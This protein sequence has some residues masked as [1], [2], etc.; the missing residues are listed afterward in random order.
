M[1]LR[2]PAGLLTTIGILAGSTA[3]SADQM[4][5]VTVTAHRPH[6]VAAQTATD[7]LSAAEKA[8]NR[9]FKRDAL[10]SRV[11]NLWI[12]PTNDQNSVFV[13]YELR[14]PNGTGSRRQLAVLEQ[15]GAEVTRIVDL[16][17]VPATRVA[18]AASGG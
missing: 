16:V 15:K 5:T 11:S 13:Q 9:Y 1:K 4:E 8:M 7:E 3:Y 12:Y 17:G 6:T 10:A 14:N 18:S 2:L